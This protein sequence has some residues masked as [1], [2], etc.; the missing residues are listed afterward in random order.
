VTTNI[1]VRAEFLKD[2][3]DVIKKLLAA[4]VDEINWINSNPDQARQAF[5]TEQEK[6]T[7]KSMP[8]DLLRESFSRL[9]LTYDPIASSLFA[10]ADNQYKVGFLDAKPDL[11][12]IY[13][14][15]L[16]NQVLQEKGLSQVSSDT[17]APIQSNVSS[18]TPSD[19]RPNNSVASS[20]VPEFGPVVPIIF[21]IAVTGIVAST[22]NTRV[23]SR[24]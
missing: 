17:N 19:Q 16:L 22:A 6:L 11:S 20:V 24:L 21:A 15:T 2:H 23:I 4:N 18:A 7:T 5:N 1:V 3:P 14:L 12:G 13:D 8:D 10:E 9:D